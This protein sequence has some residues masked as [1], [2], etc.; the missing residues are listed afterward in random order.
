MVQVYCLFSSLYKSSKFLIKD[1]TPWFSS[2]NTLQNFIIFFIY[3][4]IYTIF[5]FQMTMAQQWRMFSYLHT[6]NK[7]QRQQK[8]CW[9]GC[10]TSTKSHINKSYFTS[11]W[12]I[13]KRADFEWNVWMILNQD[14]LKMSLRTKYNK[15]DLWRSERWTG[16]QQN[17]IHLLKM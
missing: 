13:R 14:P 4:T 5:L 3:I 15:K 2:W 12:M 17:E 8:G 10:L 16:K 9:K 11:F 1:E 7:R 6:E